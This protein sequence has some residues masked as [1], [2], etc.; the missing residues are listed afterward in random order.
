M[1]TW[2]S[3]FPC[4]TSFYVG[5]ASGVVSASLRSVTEKNQ[6]PWKGDAIPME[7]NSSTPVE[8]NWVKMPLQKS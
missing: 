5:V 1:E 8:T 3:V 2:H 7:M 4:I 6:V